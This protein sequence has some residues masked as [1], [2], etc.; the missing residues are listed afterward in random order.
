M[1]LRQPRAEVILT[2]NEPSRERPPFSA[3]PKKCPE[4]ELGARGCPQTGH[5]GQRDGIDCGQLLSSAHSSGREDGVNQGQTTGIENT[6]L[7]QSFK[8]EW[9]DFPGGS[10]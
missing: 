9:E 7:D 8:I 10:V 4:T 5:C 6:G 1:G 3:F 2:A